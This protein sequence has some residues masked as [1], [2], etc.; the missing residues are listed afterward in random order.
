[1]EAVNV[2]LPPLSPREEDWAGVLRRGDCLD[3]NTTS[4]TPQPRRQAW[5]FSPFK[6]QALAGLWQMKYSSLKGP[7]DADAPRSRLLSPH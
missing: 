2:L 3:E 5:I 7:S 6:Y 4:G 1:M